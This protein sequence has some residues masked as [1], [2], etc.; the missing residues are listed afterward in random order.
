MLFCENKTNIFAPFATIDPRLHGMF[1]QSKYV[2]IVIIVCVLVFRIVL[3]EFNK[4]G[5]MGAWATINYTWYCN[6]LNDEYGG[7]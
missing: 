2:Y 4:I 6:T 3:G 7:T 1:N 5:K